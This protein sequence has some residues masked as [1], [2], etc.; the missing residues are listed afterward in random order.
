M[1]MDLCHLT[2]KVTR[3]TGM[4]FSLHQ[5]L[6]LTLGLLPLPRTLELYRFAPEA[7][8]AG[9]GRRNRLFCRTVLNTTCHQ[10]R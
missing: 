10:C 9:Y 1:L 8:R 6:T 7:G 5:F 2:L 4:T 3:I